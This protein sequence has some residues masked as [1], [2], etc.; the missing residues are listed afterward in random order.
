MHVT[1]IVLNALSTADCRRL[2]VALH[3]RNICAASRA[4]HHHTGHR[5]IQWRSA[6]LHKQHSRCRAKIHYAY[7]PLTIISIFA[8]NHDA[9]QTK[10][11]RFLDLPPELRNYIYELA[12]IHSTD[13]KPLK[14]YRRRRPSQGHRQ[15]LGVSKQLRHEALLIYY[16]QNHFLFNSTPSDLHAWLQVI[17][18]S[19]VRCLMGLTLETR[20]KCWA[21]C[22]VEL[23]YIKVMLGDRVQSKVIV[24][25]QASGADPRKHHRCRCAADCRARVRDGGIFAQKLCDSGAGKI[26]LEVEEGFGKLCRYDK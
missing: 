16:S 4:S 15:L 14:I 18:L 10:H 11:F 20:T 24:R 21:Y 7:K 6:R 22:I 23:R 13:T 17:G 19:V 8:T 26:D 2:A 9:P 3:P 1:A 12:L 5:K 25:G